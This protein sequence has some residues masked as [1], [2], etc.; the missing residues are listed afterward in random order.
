MDEGEAAADVEVQVM[1]NAEMPEVLTLVEE[2][3]RAG[4]AEVLEGVTLV[5]E[6]TRVARVGFVE[7]L[8]GV[9][10]AEEVKKKAEVAKPPGEDEVVRSR[11]FSTDGTR[12]LQ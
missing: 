7:V 6:V 12:R 4:V 2:V 5:E 8:E 3:T 1:V 9:T 10:L 11:L